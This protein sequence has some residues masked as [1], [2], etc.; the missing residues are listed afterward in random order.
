MRGRREIGYAASMSDAARRRRSVLS[1]RLP[2]DGPA[3]RR[4]SDQLPTNIRPTSDQLP[5]Q[6]WAWSEVARGWPEVGRGPMP[7][8]INGLM[9]G[10][11]RAHFRPT[12][13]QLPTNFRSD[14]IPWVGPENF[15]PPNPWPHAAIPNCGPSGGSWRHEFHLFWR[16]SAPD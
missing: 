16:N 11:A 3:F 1:D 8:E 12:S 5:T 13:G 4:T 9:P 6:A 15:Y 10:R 2:T 14:P 7:D